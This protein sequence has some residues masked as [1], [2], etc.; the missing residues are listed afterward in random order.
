MKF[1]K[2]LTIAFVFLSISAQAQFNLPLLNTAFRTDIQKVVADYP[3][4]FATLKGDVIEQ[5]PQSI[6]YISLLKP[7]GSQE[8]CIIKHSATGKAIYSWQALMLMTEEFSEAEK[9]YKWLFNQLKGMPVEYEADSY[10][11]KG[12]YGFPDQSKK[13]A[14]STLVLAAPSSPLQKLKIEVSMQYEFPDWK[15]RLLLYEKE[16]EDDE[17]GDILEQ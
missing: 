10:I 13:F 12:Q 7:A 1:L 6:E 3:H 17:R 9:K 4:Q 16:R 2:P 5:N 15:V 11:L 8:S 14:T